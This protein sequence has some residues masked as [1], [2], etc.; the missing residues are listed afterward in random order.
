MISYLVNIEESKKTFNERL[1]ELRTERRISQTDIGK[2]LGV[3][4]Q[5]VSNWENDN[6][7]PSMEIICK[8]ATLF[9]CTTDYLLCRSDT[10][11]IDTSGLT[12]TQIDHINLLIDDFRKLNKANN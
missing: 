5:S 8:L 10:H 12:D 11:L 6:I 7:L 4:K 1:K 2:A 3:T 9:N